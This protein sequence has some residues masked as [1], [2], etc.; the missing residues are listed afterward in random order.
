MS[1]SE[2]VSHFFSCY[3]GYNSTVKSTLIL[4]SKVQS[5]SK[6]LTSNLF[7]YVYGN[8]LSQL[9]K[10]SPL[11]RIMTTAEKPHFRTSFVE[12]LFAVPFLV[13]HL[14]MADSIKL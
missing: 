2:F 3:S 9:W 14:S 7:N 4:S 6:S 10:E 1:S 11:L 8:L 13:E 5:Q 12:Q